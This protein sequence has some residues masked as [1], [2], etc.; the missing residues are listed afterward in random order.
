MTLDFFARRAHYLDHLAPIWNALPSERRGR[1][2]VAQ[3]LEPYA[4]QE[5]REPQILIFEGGVPAG[6][7]PILTAAYGD[8]NK[9]IR[10]PARK[11]I[12]S[13][14][15]GSGVTWRKGGGTGVMTGYAILLLSALATMSPPAPPLTGLWGGN[16]AIL[17]IGPE[18]G[19][20]QQEC[21]YASFGPVRPDGEGRFRVTGVLEPATPG[22]QRADGPP[23]GA[24]TVFEGQ[25]DGQTLILTIKPKGQDAQRLTLIKGMRAKM[26]RC[27]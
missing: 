25:V 13:R 22:P 10:N 6:D 24:R 1:F 8:L 15:A 5:L 2:H 18:G 26:V 9:A 14:S 17:T 19:R 27:L 20:L 16:R 4:H 3:E 23:A 11:I 7:N 21:G 12:T